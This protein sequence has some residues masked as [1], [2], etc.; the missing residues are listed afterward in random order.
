MSM[1]FPLLLPLA[2]LAI[3]GC[4]QE[5]KSA[6]VRSFGAAGD[7]ENKDTAAFQRAIDNCAAQGG[8][9]VFVP[10]GKYL[11]GS[12]E[13]KSN[14][15][16][17]LDQETYLLGSPDLEDYPV[18]KSRWEGVW[19][20]AHRGLI[21]AKNADHIAI[22][23]PGHIAGSSMLGGRQM[24]RRPV[25]IEPIGCNGVILDGFSV[26]QRRMWTIHP[27]E[28]QNI[29]AKNLY[30]RTTTGNGDGI[31]V[32]SCKHVQIENCDIDTG[33]DCIALKSGRGLEA[34][35]E[36]KPTEDVTISN[37]LLGDS[38]FACIG[39][40]SETS[41]GI[42]HVRIEH[43]TFTHS[44]TFSIYIKSH[45][46]RGA[47]I[48]DISGADLTVRSATGGFLRINL[49]SSGQAG[50][51]PVTGNEGVPSGKDFSFSNVNV[52]Q[53]NALVEATLISPIKPLNGLTLSNIRG[54]CQKGMALAN[55]ASADF[56]NIN[57]TIANGPLYSIWNVKGTGME[58][59]VTTQ[60]APEP[61]TTRRLPGPSTSSAN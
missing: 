8:G 38:I 19:V 22:I 28:C 41:G 59:A 11:I 4:T 44:K 33:D 57:V 25:V 5:L 26:Q 23:G 13:L 58:N 32:D 18:V 45:I 30:I 20:D 53:C 2:L 31:D 36:A 9:Q 37:C 34:Y 16:L 49:T 61:A 39:M 52:A 40:G 56:S 47:S 14:V 43:C 24:P 50:N 51:D 29:V 10:A 12:I 60:P 3:V 7:G 35:R 27:L 6:D 1:K 42:R 54:E 21:Y 55:I 17:C 46:G 48:Q 15:T